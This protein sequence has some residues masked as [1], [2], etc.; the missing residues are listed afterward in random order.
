M[1]MY[2]T[3]YK[4]RT[5]AFDG[6]YIIKINKRR[7]KMEQTLLKLVV[8]APDL[9]TPLTPDT[10]FN[11]GLSADAVSRIQS[12]GLIVLVIIGIAL[13]ALTIIAVQRR[14][15]L[16]KVDFGASIN[17]KKYVAVQSALII[18]ILGMSGYLGGVVIN[19]YNEASAAS[20]IRVATDGTLTLNA[21]LKE[22]EPV[23][24]CGT[25]NVKI[26]QA[27]PAG[28]KLSMHAGDIVMSGSSDVK[29]ESTSNAGELAPSAWGY[30]LNTT[31][32]VASILPV[33]SA[34]T[35]I[36]TVTTETSA[37][38]IIKVSYCVN[39]ASDTEPGTYTTQIKYLVEPEYLSY[40]LEYDANGGV[41]EEEVGVQTS[42]NTLAPSYQFEITDAVPVLANETEPENEA[43]TNANTSRPASATETSTATES[44]TTT[45]PETATESTTTTESEA[46]TE[47]ATTTEPATNEEPSSGAT[48]AK[49]FFGW[50]LSGDSATE[51]YVA[52]DKITVTEPHTTLKA[53]WGYD[54]HTITYHKNTTDT[55]NSFVEK[56]YC[57]IMEE[58][59][60][61]SCTTVVTSRVPVRAGY[62][63][64]GWSKQAYTPGTNDT[65]DTARQKVDYLP[66]ANISLTGDTDLH[67]VWWQVSTSDFQVELRWGE[68][69][70]DLDTHL[71]AVKNSDHTK[72]FE[73]YYSHKTERIDNGTI[74]LSVNLDVD[75]TS[76]YGPE[77]L[78]LDML[79]ESA[80]S[81]YTFYYCIYNYSGES[82]HKI[83]ESG[84]NI[85]LIRQGETIAEYNVSAAAGASKR[86]WN[87]FAIKNGEIVVRNTL[88]DRAET[89]Y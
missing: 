41:F 8:S 23:L 50:S 64:L 9:P 32:S 10:G 47:T 67:A 80:Y 5:L 7:E 60:T 42:G 19:E 72:V 34:S 27:L 22:S 12:T 35:V 86:Y 6:D 83:K 85:T 87:V 54:K 17:N 89:D 74:N 68:K 52:G 88:T 3:S 38:E 18:T 76:S 14:K 77:T 69:P 81:D 24:V 62:T 1:L 57:V 49:S 55:V 33:P 75:D 21:Q 59:A 11:T 53:V 63:L 37:D 2:N 65:I 36:K 56:Q 29:I 48:L 73:V 4:G 31:P 71:Y 66:G 43:G 26:G 20:D 82:S 61:N 15:R 46:T 13:L 30:T 84:A 28:Y 39:L 79:P 44:T 25:D 16:S 70:R 40:E 78:T 45:E 58:N 51:L